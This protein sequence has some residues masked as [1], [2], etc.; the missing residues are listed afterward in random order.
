M[1]QGQQFPIFIVART[2]PNQRAFDDFVNRAG[3]AGTRAANAMT[4]NLSGVRDTVAQALSLPR[5]SFGSLDLNI[6][7]LKQMEL[8][9]EAV[10][11]A[12][13]EYAL[14]TKSAAIGSGETTRSRNQ[15]IRSAFELARVEEENL[16]QLRT[17]IRIMD[18][19]QT[20]LNQTASATDRVVA[21]NRR[22]TS[23][24]GSVI[25]GLRAQRVASL[26][27]GQQLQ[28][29]TI[30]YQM[31]TNGLTIFSQQVP[32]AAFALSGLKDSSDDTLSKI[33]DFAT[34]LSGPWGAAIFAATAVLGPFILKM[35]DA[36]SALSQ[37]NEEM[38]KVTMASSGLADAQG[39]L[40]DMF[41]LA[42]GKIKDQNEILRLNAQ[43]KSA[44]L[45]AD[46]E[47]RAE[48]SKKQFES[49]SGGGYSM[50][51]DFSAS[52]ESEAKGYKRLREL[53]KIA[54]DVT[55]GRMSPSSAAGWAQKFDFS[56]LPV[57]RAEFLQAIADRVGSEAS[58]ATADAIDRSLAGSVLDP[59]LRRQDSGRSSR[60]GLY[61]RE[62]DST[63]ARQ[64]AQ[65]AGFQVNSA[66][67]TLGQ[68]Q[69]LYDQWVAA[70]K[71]KDNPVAV[72]NAN[73][74]HVR[75]SA[76][77]IQFGAGVSPESIRKAFDAEGVR[78]TKILKERGHYHIE[79]STKGSDK[80][81]REAERVAEAAKRHSEAIDRLADSS[82]ERV[83]R[84]NEAF[85]EQPK[86]IDRAN[87]ATRELDRTMADLE[88][89]LVNDATLTDQQRENMAKT[90]AEAVKAKATI[91]DALVRPFRELR[92]ESERR[93]QVETLLTQ[94]REDEARALQ[95]IWRL[96][97]TL[98]PLT[99]KRKAEILGIVRN[100]REVTEE[101]RRR[102]EI[103]G[104][105]LEATRSVK[106]ELVSIFS[107]QG[108]FANFGKIFKQLNSQI[109][110]E[111]LFGG[112]L[113]DFDK[114]IKGQS[115]L[116]DSV[117]YLA[118]ETD[119]GAGAVKTFAD[120]VLDQARRIANPGPAG[121]SLQREFD[122]T[123][124][125]AGGFVSAG[126]NVISSW[127]SAVNDNTAELVVTGKRLT[128]V[129]KSIETN[130]SPEQWAK[131]L[132]GTM[133]DSALAAFGIKSKTLQGILGG[134][135]YG[136]MTGGP[137]G[138][139]LGGL[140]GIPGL[141]S[142]LSGVL[143]NGVS[144][145]R[146]SQL[147]QGL[148]ASV[149]I[150]LNGTGSSIGG[151]AG[152]MIG[153]IWGPAGEQA[154]SAIGSILGGIFGKLFGKRPRG[155]AEVSNS[156]VFAHTNDSGLTSSTNDWGGAVQ[157]AVSRIADALGVN[158]GNYSI[159]LGR[160]RDYYQVS[161][162]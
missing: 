18:Q 33:G 104:Q 97:S 88:D 79:W 42:T 82:S 63:T 9:L 126:G 147:I 118:S 25:N 141:S 86:L 146:N 61:G 15:E 161:T 26:Q 14:A 143:D 144:G 92:E 84:I 91:Q 60:S 55:R 54:D 121:G 23:E 27:L 38:Q 85:D 70:G 36:G 93:L 11:K 44:Q 6:T 81:I 129:S 78:L 131:K 1:T 115:G 66:D 122:A 8:E 90:Y 89:K 157:S 125:G 77:D 99:E 65:S 160:Y 152:G 49:I 31:G 150:R 130:L 145:A 87:Q 124:A 156:S 133:A 113:R 68:Q 111:K 95:E 29:M 21:A 142:G 64:I 56:G 53:K 20:E 114:W 19:V 48:S 67:R 7:Q 108:S 17:K 45:R 57:T 138:A 137:V 123:F 43:L 101:L 41:D 149:G 94:G 34:F 50:F 24:N 116:G 96:E 35:F 136:N 117:D 139:V 159:G 22:G 13:R 127:L 83:S 105:Y 110:V 28:D 47:A 100:E 76:L 154:G 134:A 12:T 106:Q 112:A 40:G 132:S 52:G 74:P 30:Q 102:Q 73:A 119:R 39:V 46:S 32:Q 71:P 16:A 120:V 3:D 58:K 162:Q 107:G 4:R 151:A 128:G 158:V 72:P 148:A 59:S 37:T 51:S 155:A 103:I 2:D 140:Q 69:R 153:G 10:A 5:N 75:G 80:A 109:L 135:L 98:G 62:I